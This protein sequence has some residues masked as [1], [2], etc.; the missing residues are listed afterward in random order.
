MGGLLQIALVVRMGLIPA[1]TSE[2]VVKEYVQ[3]R[4]INLQTVLAMRT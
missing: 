1:L 4:T 3:E 2:L